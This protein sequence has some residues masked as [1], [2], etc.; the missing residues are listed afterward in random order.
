MRLSAREGGSVAAFADVEH[1]LTE[2]LTAER[3]RRLEEE[4]YA[5]LRQQVDI[6]I[7]RQAL[8]TVG[9]GD[10][11]AAARPPSFP[12]GEKAP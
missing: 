7:D 2:R 9:P 12:V 3:K 11:A 5:A 4:R 1:G 8:G 6:T 10:L